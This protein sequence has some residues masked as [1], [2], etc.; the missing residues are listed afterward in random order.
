MEE[1]ILPRKKKIPRCLDDGS[2][3]NSF[4]SETSKDWFRAAYLEVLDFVIEAIKDHFDQPGYAIYHNLEDLLGKGAA[5]QEFGDEM[6]Q[7]CQL[8]P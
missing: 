7:V 8:L 3:N 2:A 1:S 5:G 6:K 4:S